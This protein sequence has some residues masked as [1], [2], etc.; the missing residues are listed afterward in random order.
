MRKY[1]KQELCGCI[2]TLKQAHIKMNNV[3]REI[4]NEILPQCQEMAIQVGTEIDKIAGEGTLAVSYLEQYCEAVYQAAVSTEKQDWNKYQ[5]EVEKLLKQIDHSIRF[6]IADTPAEIVFL[7]YKASMWDALDS[8]YRAA[9][10]DKDCHVVVMPI[11]YYNINPQGE[12]LGIEYEA[13][14]FPKDIEITDFRDYKLEEQHPDVIFIH[15]PYD[16]WNR[17]TQVPQEYFSS[18]LV[19]CTERLVYI[20]YF[21]TKGD[22]IKEE[23]CRMPAIGNA[24]R[25]FVQSE[26][27]RK[28]YIKYGA[29]SE[30][31]VTMGS[32]K[33]D[34][35]I[36]MQENQPVIPKEWEEALN[37]RKIFLLNTHLNAIINE[38]EKSVDKIHQ[39][40]QLFRERNDVALLWRPHPLSIQT[41]KALSPY[42]LDRYI[43]L[44][45]EFKTLPNGVYDDSTDVHRAMA[46]SDAYVG[47]WSSLVTMYG[48]TGK[49][50]YAMNFKVDTH[51]RKKIETLSFSSVAELDGYWWAAADDSNGLYKIDINSGRAE[52]VAWFDREKA[53]G[54][55]LYRSIVAYKRKLFLIPFVGNFIAEYHV[56]T[57]AIIYYD[58]PD[59]MSKDVCKFGSYTVKDNKL[60]MFPMRIRDI[61]CL[62][63][64]KGEN[65]ICEWN[66]DILLN[67]LVN[68]NR[69]MFPKAIRVGDNVYLPCMH[70]D[71]VLRINLIDFQC[72]MISLLGVEVQQGFISAVCEGDI[73]YL[74]GRKGD[75]FRYNLQNGKAELFYINDDMTELDGEPYFNILYY[76]DSLVLVAGYSKHNCIININTKQITKIDDYPM[77]CSILNK[78]GY[79]ECDWFGG[80]TKDEKLFLFPCRANMLLCWEDILQQPKG[81]KIEYLK[82][83]GWKNLTVDQSVYKEEQYSLQYF[84]EMIVENKDDYMEER[85]KHFRELQYKADGFSGERIWEYIQRMR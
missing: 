35:V 45:E 56:D 42:I 65:R 36:K 55:K 1:K 16:E 9:I 41:A 62:D 76:K 73:L 74:L 28:C 58:V 51:I 43:Q 52:F 54:V 20:P 3:N 10:Q 31:I 72:E 12:V 50:I 78:Q 64:E 17:V 7:P 48:I 44:I 11:P 63:M 69:N 14:L 82:E 71:T 81:T 40:F 33:F 53:R 21:V 29:D 75:V 39:I 46:L 57:H 84:I 83:E 22:D 4:R 24:W 8:V 15:N 18:S 60:F 49:P 67:S 26:A 19:Q 59:K 32:P 37:G 38:A 66:K 68:D 27:I 25:T 13:A 34:M 85:K 80:E 77:G 61:V 79:G 30:K 23:Y 47:D 2:N 6:D 5:K 70:M